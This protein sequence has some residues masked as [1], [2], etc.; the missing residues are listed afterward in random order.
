MVTVTLFCGMTGGVSVGME[1]VLEVLVGMT[2]TLEVL[3]ATTTRVGMGISTAGVVGGEG[4]ELM[5]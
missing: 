1:L 2:R 4:N 5:E 3:G